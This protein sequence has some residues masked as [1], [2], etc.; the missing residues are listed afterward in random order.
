MLCCVVVCEGKQLA[1]QGLEISSEGIDGAEE[2]AKGKKSSSEKRENRVTQSRKGRHRK[3]AAQSSSTSSPSLLLRPI[4]PL[5]RPLCVCLAVRSFPLHGKRT[6]GSKIAL[7]LPTLKEPPS[8]TRSFWCDSRLAGEETDIYHSVVSC[9]QSF[10]RSSCRD[11]FY[12][13]QNTFP[14]TGV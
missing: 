2:Q 3:Q 11:D 9:S 14:N 13:S 7:N 1:S 4:Q 6:S 12:V 5:S 10:K 8:A